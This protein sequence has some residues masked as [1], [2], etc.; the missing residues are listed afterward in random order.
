MILETNKTLR[1]YV[2]LFIAVIAYFALHEG[3]HLLLA[4][5]YNVFE[6]VN[7]MGLGMQIAITREALSETQFIIFNLVGVVT[8]LVVGYVLVILTKKI[9]TF[10]LKAI[11]AAFYYVTLAMLFTDCIYLAVLSSFFG[12]GDLNGIALLFP[13]ETTAK[14]LFGVIGIINVFIFIKFVY[15]KYA[16]AYKE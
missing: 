1:Q 15:P 10:K 16:A 14:I 3:A 12:G 5:Y 6:Q 9:V 2:S 13:T 4:L 11:K 8:T 7:F